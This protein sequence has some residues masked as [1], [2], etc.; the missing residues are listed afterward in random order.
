MGN[1]ISK[2]GTLRHP[3]Q[4]RRHHCHTCVVVFR[5]TAGLGSCAGPAWRTWSDFYSGF[6]GCT[7]DCMHRLPPARV[8]AGQI[9]KLPPARALP[10]V[11]LDCDAACCTACL[12]LA[13]AAALHP[14]M[15]SARTA[16]WRVA[17]RPGL[18]LAT[19][20][21]SSFFGIK[22]NRY[23][24]RGVVRRGK[25]HLLCGVGL[26]LASDSYARTHE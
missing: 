18:R 15:Q 12:L 5:P 4:R 17:W 19:S 8:A 13:A 22:F 2:G 24:S 9:V 1:R 7:L 10:R 6:P 21:S 25:A 14:S 20:D 16:A 26:H 3:H 23:I 11:A